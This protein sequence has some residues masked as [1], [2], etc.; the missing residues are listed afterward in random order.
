MKILLSDIPTL[1]ICT[2][3]CMGEK[4]NS[5]SFAHENFEKYEGN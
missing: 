2:K 1:Y 4:Q 5:S 3:F